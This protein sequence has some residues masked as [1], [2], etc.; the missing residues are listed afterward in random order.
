MG[1]LLLG[2]LVLL[3]ACYV[4]AL[5]LG[6]RHSTVRLQA[7]TAA[8][9]VD[10][11]SRAVP[12]KSW[13][14]V[15]PIGVGGCPGKS[16]INNNAFESLVDT[17]DA[18]IRKRT[19][20]HN[21]HVIASGSS[22]RDIALQSAQQALKAAN[23]NPEDID[24]VV[25]ATSSPDDMF[26]D[27]P[28][29]ASALGAHKAAA[30]D[31]TA[32]CSGFLYG[33]VTAS[34]FIQ[35]GS[36]RRVLLVGADALTR[37]LDWQDRGTCIL[38]GDGAGAMVL[39]ATQSDDTS[40]LLGFALHSDGNRY[41][42]LQI[43][44]VSNFKA[45]PNA[46]QTVMDQG[47]YGKLTMNGPEVYK[48]AVNEV[49]AVIHEALLNA[50]MEASQVDWLLLHQANTRIMDHAASVLGIPSEKVIKNIDEYGN[51]SAGSIPLA[52]A[53]A[54]RAGK[55]KKGD[56]IAIAGFGAGLSWGA[57]IIRWG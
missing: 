2:L 33:L 49:P 22:L 19:G 32:A 7:S 30:F 53:E 48:F 50:G 56:V 40:G 31:L 13:F 54:V 45:L 26:G 11:R 18:W 25:V 37:F 6:S 36:Y 52:L 8:A 35:T 4:H 39:E 51:T 3:V 29:V 10:A 41:P 9:E 46:D 44:F 38:F 47:S 17:N 1:T 12:G 34:Q 43:P 28:S 55:V 27:A 42:S 5:R 14:R 21:R 16:V 15:R 24:L 23:V 20:I 57:A